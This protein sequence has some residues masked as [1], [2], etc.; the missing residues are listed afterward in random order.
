M[1]TQIKSKNASTKDDCPWAVEVQLVEQ[2][3]PTPEI[4]GYILLV[5]DKCYIAIRC[6]ET[7]LKRRK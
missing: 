2:L 7:V 4:H 1:L 6:V 5:N 3:L